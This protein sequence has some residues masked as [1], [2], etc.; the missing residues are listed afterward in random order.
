MVF[1]GLFGNYF[2]YRRGLRIISKSES[3]QED[4][5]LK[6]L[7]KHG[8]TTMVGVFIYAVIW[9]LLEMYV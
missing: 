2:Y 6:R 3:L 9:I 8:G 4:L 1:C 5:Q 7:E